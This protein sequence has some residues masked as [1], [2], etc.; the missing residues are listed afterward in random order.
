MRFVYEGNVNFFERL[1]GVGCLLSG[2]ERLSFAA[3]ENE[4]GWLQNY[5][6]VLLLKAKFLCNFV[7]YAFLLVVADEDNR[8]GKWSLHCVFLLKR[9]LFVHYVRHERVEEMAN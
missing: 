2:R 9:L 7:V 5:F 4:L 6:I 1:A 3:S 8:S